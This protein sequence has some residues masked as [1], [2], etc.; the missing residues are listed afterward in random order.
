MKQS[1]RPSGKYKAVVFEY[2]QLEGAILYA[3]ERR[4]LE[5]AHFCVVLNFSNWDSWITTVPPCNVN[6]R[7]ILHHTNPDY[8]LKG[9]MTSM[10]DKQTYA[11]VA[12]LR[13]KGYS[14]QAVADE[15]GFSVRKVHY[16]DKYNN[17]VIYDR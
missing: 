4:K 16:L 17:G 9:K 3:E 14:L 1:R 11:E 5:R 6:G 7:T 2:D 8:A 15:L 12:A 10:A 13:A